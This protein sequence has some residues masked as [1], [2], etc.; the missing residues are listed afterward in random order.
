MNSCSLY[1]QEQL[2]IAGTTFQSVVYKVSDMKNRPKTQETL[3]YNLY[4]LMEM[5]DMELETLAKKSGVSSRMIRFIMKQQRVPSVEIADKLAE[6]F[7]LTG[8][9]LIMPNLIGS[10]SEF[11]HIDSL[12]HDWLAA[13]ADGRKFIES[14]AHREAERQVS[15]GHPIAPQP[16]RPTKDED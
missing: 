1:C 3:A 10:L 16:D 2:F 8:W 7:G 6:A 9:Q 13:D 14:A 12:F 4:R 11:K 15:N 5:E